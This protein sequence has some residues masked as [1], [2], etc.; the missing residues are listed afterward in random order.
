M[1]L[2]S[3]Q[4]FGVASI[5]VKVESVDFLVTFVPQATAEQV[6]KFLKDSHAMIVDGP[7]IGMYKLRFE[8]NGAPKDETS[9]VEKELEQS[10]NIVSSGFPASTN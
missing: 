6:T 3:D 1:V 7:R 10:R 9:R 8:A 5:D 4:H 2:K